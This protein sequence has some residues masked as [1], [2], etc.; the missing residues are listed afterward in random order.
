MH[1]GA[2]FGGARFGCGHGEFDDARARAFVALRVKY[3][4]RWMLATKI[5]FR[6]RMPSRMGRCGQRVV[7]LR[8]CS[9]F[10]RPPQNG[11][12]GCLIGFVQTAAR[13]NRYASLR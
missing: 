13:R 4:A 6:K 9:V 5:A 7:A 2:S 1:A 3:A 10:S 8:T 12:F 11:P